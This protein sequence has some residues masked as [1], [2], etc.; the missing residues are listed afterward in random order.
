MVSSMEG[1]IIVGESSITCELRYLS[2]PSRK[3]IVLVR[4]TN[5]FHIQNNCRYENTE[6]VGTKG[7]GNVYPKF[8]SVSESFLAATWYGIHGMEGNQRPR[9]YCS[10]RN[11]DVC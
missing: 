6:T 8:L 1:H 7:G 9:V 5:A 4:F 3:V 2:T 11:I 10:T